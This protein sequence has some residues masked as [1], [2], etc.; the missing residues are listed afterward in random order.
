[1]RELAQVI[2]GR[3]L[4]DDPTVTGVEFDLGINQVRPELRL[5]AQDGDRGLI[6][7]GLDPQRIFGHRR[8]SG[9]NTPMNG[10]FRYSS[11]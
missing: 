8:Y 11:A 3:D 2:P 4:G 9:F 7:R 6:A 10:R 5:P 1:M